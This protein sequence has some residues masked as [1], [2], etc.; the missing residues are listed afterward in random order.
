MAEC[1][2]HR[3]RLPRVREPAGGGYGDPQ[4][5]EQQSDK[6]EDEGRERLQQRRDKTDEAVDDAIFTKARHYAEHE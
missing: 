1:A 6:C 5:E 4:A 3:H 2:R